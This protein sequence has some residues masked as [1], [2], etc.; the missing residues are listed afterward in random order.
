MGCP[1]V[2]GGRHA[3]GLF[4]WPDAEHEAARRFCSPL[5][6]ARA[7]WGDEPRLSISGYDPVAYFTDGKAVQGKPE[8]EYLW[9]R[10]RWRFANAEHRDLFT[11]DPK[12]YAPQYDGYCALGT[13]ANEAAHK[14]TVDPEAW[15]IVDGKLYLTHNRY[16]LQVWR[17]NAK[18]HIGQAD[19]DWE[20]VKNLPAPEIV[21]PPCAAS[22]PTTKVALRDGGHMGRRRRPGGPRRGRQCCGQR[23]SAGA[24]RTSW[25]ERRLRA[26]MPAARR[27]RILF[28]R[29]AMSHSPSNS[30]NTPICASAIL[31]RLRR[32][33]RRFPC[34]NWM[35][36]IF[37]CRSRPSPRFTITP[38]LRAHLRQG[39]S[40]AQV[41]TLGGIVSRLRL[42][43]VVSLYNYEVGDCVRLPHFDVCLVFRRAIAGDRGGGELNK[44]MT[45]AGRTFRDFAFVGAHQVATTEFL[46][47][48][49]AG[50]GVPP[51]AL[52]VFHVHPDYPIPPLLC[53]A[54]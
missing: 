51:H 12:H 3:E 30:T 5:S 15:A 2:S 24:D 27:S 44:D 37:L 8:F 7:A 10:L 31:A 28:L 16:L 53:N 1:A 13:S 26:S 38:G 40:T 17:E 36:R 14:D 50:G 21:G 34:R 47:D 20:A 32:R 49:R 46:V 33:A 9:R 22:P 52:F 39:P 42:W 35:A 6:S 48:R 23:R 45:R 4:F 41:G 43:P 54:R 25:Q 29:S 11:R 18:D 19:Q